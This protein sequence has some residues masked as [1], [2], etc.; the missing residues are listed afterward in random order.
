[1]VAVAPSLRPVKIAAM[2]DASTTVR[3]TALLTKAL[4]IVE[5]IS[6]SDNRLKFKDIAE[7]TGHSK[8]TL[9]RILSA[10]TA[11][12]MIDIDRRDQSY[13]LGPKFTRMAGSINS[14]SDLIA[15]S[16][17]PLKAIAD[18]HGE[19][20]NLAILSGTA[21]I[22]I[23]RWQ[24]RL[25]QGFSSPLG[26]RKPLHATSLGKALMAFLLVPERQRLI[27]Q[28]RLQPYTPRTLTDAGALEADLELC[29]A[30]GFALDDNEIIEGVTCVAVPVMDPD[31]A[32]IAA[33][34]ITAPSHRMGLTRR[35]ELASVL[36]GAV[37]QIT[38]QLAPP[39]RAV[40]ESV[41]LTRARLAVTDLRAFS[42]R[43]AGWSDAFGGLVW[44]DGPAGLVAVQ[45]A[46]EHRPLAQFGQVHAVALRARGDLVILADGGLWQLSPDLPE[47][48]P[49][50]APAGLS[51]AG[52][53]VLPDGDLLLLQ[54]GALSR[55]SPASG[56]TVLLAAGFEDG[57]G[58]DLL[59]GRVHLV[60]EGG[61]K[62]LCLDLATGATAMPDLPVQGALG[63]IAADGAGGFWLAPR[64]AWS[65]CHVDAAGIAT[66]LPIP[67]PG[68]QG[69]A[70]GR[71]A[72][73][74]HAGSDR[75][76]L[77]QNMLDI[78]PMAGALLHV[79]LPEAAQPT[80]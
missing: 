29:R 17:G 45:A 34:S 75:M 28:L 3:G 76:A 52:M 8:S 35:L 20:V 12:G 62:V 9:Y 55:L 74:L 37:R 13:V 70:R 51:A 60:A 15:V 16:A 19:N 5:L 43:A 40:T 14:S 49:L 23:S 41:A 66:H 24:G 58:F 46:S 21:H 25:A 22:T 2:N 36:Q 71:G 33:V 48:Q 54:D 50:G 68:A 79:S 69:L 64:L 78:A 44:H 4:D 6:D 32:V 18:L 30:R 42:P 47:P 57:P 59:D 27:A 10:L 67:V 38:A 11:R 53:A 7:R 63:G 77:S 80:R 26:E 56:E 39:R 73:E 72:G 31:G 65:L 61:Q 1:M